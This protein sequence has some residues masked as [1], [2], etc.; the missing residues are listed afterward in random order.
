MNCPK[1]KGEMEE[2][3]VFASQ[4]DTSYGTTRWGQKKKVLIGW[5]WNNK[6]ESVAFR[7]TKC[8]YL[9]SYAK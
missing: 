4:G 3:G 6:K 2:G 7:C 5:I 8:G 9:E 1:C